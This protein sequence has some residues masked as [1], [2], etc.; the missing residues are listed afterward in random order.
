MAVI[1]LAICWKW[2]VM[3][4]RPS[5]RFSSVINRESG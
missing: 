4:L 5:P 3:S 1:H 2:R